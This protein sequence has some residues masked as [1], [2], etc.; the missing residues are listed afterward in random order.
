M[1]E[2]SET[3]CKYTLWRLLKEY[4]VVI[5]RIQRDYA[6]G[7]TSDNVSAIREE[8]LNSIH[9]AL[10]SHQRLDFDF[11]YGTVRE[12]ILYPLDGQQRLTTFYLLHW[13][14]AQKE[15]CQDVAMPVLSSFSYETRVSSRDFC[16][17][18]MK[19]DYSPVRDELVSDYIR[20]ENGY[21]QEWDMDPTISNMLIMLDAIHEKFYSTSQL[22]NLLVSD[23]DML[24]FSYLPM[25]RYALTDDLYIKMNA[26]GKAL[27]DFENFKAKFI[28]HMKEKN[29]SY[30]HFEKSIDSSWTDLLW[31]YRARNNTIDRQFMNLFLFITE[32]LYLER[33]QMRDDSP[34][35]ASRIRLLI[36]FYEDDESIQ[37]LYKY[38]DLW[39]NRAEVRDCLATFLT[40]E[41]E[42]GK[43]RLF[44][45]KIDIFGA[46]V[47]GE[48][49]SI[50]NR[51]ILFAIMKRLVLKGKN[52]DIE[53]M[54]D[55]IRV[56]RNFLLNT[57]SFNSRRCEFSSD[58]RFGRHAVPIMQ[59]LI[60]PLAEK[61]QVYR[62]LSD[63]DL[64]GL[65]T[66]IC[67]LEKKK[68]EIII[69]SP[70]KK[71]T[72]QS[73][74][75]MDMFRSSIF[76][77]LPYIEENDDDCLIE[78]MI[79]LSECHEAKVI[80]ALLSISDYEIRVGSGEYGERF[81]FGN[82]ED[83]YS[84]FTYNGGQKYC[85]LICEF[86]EQFED[87]ESDTV[88]DSL[89]EIVENNLQYIAKND[90]RYT[91]VKYYN[92]LKNWKDCNHT[93]IILSKEYCSDSSI[94]L[95]RLNGFKFNT[96]H[97]VPEYLE[98]RIQ[99]GNLCKGDVRSFG[100]DPERQGMIR[101]SC[102]DGLSVQ[103][104]KDGTLSVEFD[105][106]DSEWVNEIV[107]SYDSQENA[108]LDS[109]ERFVLLCRMLDTRG[110]EIYGAYEI[111]APVYEEI[112]V[113][114]RRIKKNE[115]LPEYP[116]EKPSSSTS[117][118]SKEWTQEAR[119]SFLKEVFGQEMPVLDNFD[120][121]FD[122]V[123]K[124]FVNE[125]IRKVIIGLWKE[126][127]SASQIAD[128]IGNTRSYVY[129]LQGKGMRM[130]RHPSRG[131]YFK[132]TNE[133]LK[134]KDLSKPI[135]SL[136]LQVG[137]Y[138]MLKKSGIYTLGDIAKMSQADLKE[139]GCTG[140]QRHD[141]WRMLCEEGVDEDVQL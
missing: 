36:D 102:A 69:R 20:N 55:Y 47:S 118:Q 75:D 82:I 52:T 139:I 58:V 127:K 40:N 96:Y 133:E 98:I 27:S 79:A 35:T 11:V 54:K 123:M 106:Q 134:Q 30:D 67:S 137:T 9:A 109:V 64:S 19:I 16:E 131:R 124:G 114:E 112:I 48:S 45:G 32:M 59:N 135:E 62:F 17:L 43:V 15:K 7:R 66:E 44:E 94:I 104:S 103:Y 115:A 22:F 77:I 4:R 80:Q 12:G 56:V 37:M 49:V 38:L 86:V 14:L 113:P 100:C 120:E 63:N 71:Q 3:G 74:E 84:L 65:N 91:I 132:M 2:I 97:V 121:S 72:I 130:L 85:E 83:W 73:A 39:A 78:N 122:Y 95:H 46:I 1:S 61:E 90:W 125:K 76:N 5:P 26:R 140:A 81:F 31:D 87:A 99:L 18:L 105:E 13:Y 89:N 107:E 128:E 117:E 129:A 24:T 21:F 28:Q 126:K 116:E 50:P 88:Y 101:L 70:E 136:N 141:V 6:Q 10:V 93:Y 111:K 68:A 92:T 60:G 119:E 51:L 108:N 34:F 8:L 23:L 29:L 110:Q 42:A 53:D 33:T 57:R 25:E 41:H 138:N